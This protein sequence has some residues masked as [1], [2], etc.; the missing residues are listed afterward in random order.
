MADE[1]CNKQETADVTELPATLLRVP[2]SIA[3]EDHRNRVS[4]STEAK[5]MQSVGSGVN[6]EQ[7]HD[8]SPLI[9]SGPNC[10]GTSQK[11]VEQSKPPKDGELVEN[12]R[13][14]AA[15]AEAAA[16]A[17]VPVG[18]IQLVE[19]E[20]EYPN[21]AVSE[22]E[23]PLVKP[24]A[25]EQDVH[26]KEEQE[27]TEE[28]SPERRTSAIGDEHT[29]NDSAGQEQT[30]AVEEDMEIEGTECIEPPS[31]N[32]ECRRQQDCFWFQQ[33]GKQPSEADT[34]KVETTDLSVIAPIGSLVVVSTGV[35][36]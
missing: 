9:G 1:T 27:E 17:G 28:K 15:P 35:A 19:N 22:L 21:Q 33:S 2:E 29:L 14:L 6:G 11:E 25:Q 32:I 20:Q 16:A 26:Q 7:K 23:K 24:E 18:N 10:D 30:P 8:D 31:Q 5:E 34:D 3:Y 4:T 12:D 13:E 36:V